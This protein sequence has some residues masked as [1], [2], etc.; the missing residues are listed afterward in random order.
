MQI[1]SETHIE[2]I[3][4]KKQKKPKSDEKKVSAKK[5][6]FRIRRCS[7]VYILALYGVGWKKM[8][9]I[10]LH[11]AYLGKPKSQLICK[12]HWEYNVH[13]VKSIIICVSKMEGQKNF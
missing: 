8:K 4:K 11:N 12:P 9:S 7:Y 10:I 6:G 13:I 1:E 5:V 3:S 2:N